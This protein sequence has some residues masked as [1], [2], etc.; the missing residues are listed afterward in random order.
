MGPIWG[1]QV[2]GGPYVGPMNLTIWV[3]TCTELLL[4]S[5][6]IGFGNCQR[7]VHPIEYAHSF[8]CDV[9]CLGYIVDISIFV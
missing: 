2:S 7:R 9:F 3:M 5:S 6:A 4:N 1:R 8:G